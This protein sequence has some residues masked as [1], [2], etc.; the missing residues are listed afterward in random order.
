MSEFVEYERFCP[1]P[2]T[3]GHARR[4]SRTMTFAIDIALLLTIVCLAY[5]IHQ[6][7]SGLLL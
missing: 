4:P 5:L 6:T 7:L 1:L 3:A 2:K